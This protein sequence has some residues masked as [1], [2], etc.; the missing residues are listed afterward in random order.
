MPV[1]FDEYSESDGYGGSIEP[2]SNSHEILSFLAEHPEQGFTPTEIHEHVD[3]PMGSI[4]PT[5]KRL[6]ERELVRHK[7]PYWAIAR[8]DRIGGFEA[9][10]R[11]LEAIADVDDEWDDVDWEE[12]AVDESE[13]ES[14]RASQRSDE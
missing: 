2:G 9:T 14:W 11:S 7:G 10:Q 13:I 6:E 5:L 12:E 4:G 1:E 8:D 3:I